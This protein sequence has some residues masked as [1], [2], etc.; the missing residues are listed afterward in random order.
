METKEHIGHWIGVTQ[1]A[2][3]RKTT[4]YL[5][6]FGLTIKQYGVLNI[7]YHEDGLTSRELVDRTFSDS[8]TI[9][10]I[11]DQLEKKGF[12]TRESDLR[13]RR[14]K[15]LVLTNKAKKVE[16]ELVRAV[17]E[18][19]RVMLADFTED[20][21]RNLKTSLLKLLKFANVPWK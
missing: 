10:A 14:L 3:M 6:R 16:V 20:E 7:L 17:D 11:V 4:A 18:F 15:H 8:S 5:R 21:T 19:D 13:D 12:I 2:L 9:M 1:N